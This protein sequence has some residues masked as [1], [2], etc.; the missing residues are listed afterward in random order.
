[1]NPNEVGVIA[2]SIHVDKSF[3]VKK[4]QHNYIE[5]NLCDLTY[6]NIKHNTTHHKPT[7]CNRSNFA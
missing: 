7:F 2:Q 5:K 1:M 4:L 3:E 6:N